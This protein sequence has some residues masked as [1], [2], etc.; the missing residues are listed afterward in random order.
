[1]SRLFCQA[2][3]TAFAVALFLLPAC[4]ETAQ[5]VAPQKLSVIHRSAWLGENEG[6]QLIAETVSA[7]PQGEAVLSEHE[8]LLSRFQLPAGSSLMRLHLLCSDPTQLLHAGSLQLPDGTLF[9]ALG[10]AP[11]SLSRADRLLWDTLALGGLAV[12][13]QAS[14]DSHR[15]SFL[16]VSSDFRRHKPES[17]KW[18]R[19]ESSTALSYRAWTDRERQIFLEGPPLQQHD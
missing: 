11:A 17:V 16:L 15:R 8:V 6:L 18:S 12:G 13:Q 4:T 5:P 2:A 7:P 1:M 14:I 9:Q 19:G 10:A 3:A